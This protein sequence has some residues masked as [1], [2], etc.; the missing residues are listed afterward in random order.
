M[1]PPNWGKR[2]VPPTR[3]PGPAQALERIN[4]TVKTTDN[5]GLVTSSAPVTISVYN[6]DTDLNWLPDSWE[7]QFFGAI[8]QNPN[9]LAPAGDGYTILQ[10]YDLGRSP[11]DFY[12]GVAPSVTMISGNNQ[13]GL[14][15]TYLPQ[16][17]T[18]RV[19]GTSG[20]LQKNAPVTFSIATG[21]G[22][23]GLSS[24]SGAI[25][26]SVT[27]RTGTNGLASVYLSLS[28]T[29]GTPMTRD[30]YWYRVFDAG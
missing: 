23:L 9:A 13:A 27:V 11:L 16:P 3:S 14:I 17:L 7:L 5:Y 22:S 8:G 1:A 25:G 26:S 18:V 21:G 30:C 24:T 15:N 6:D 20:A 2:P 4:L 19:S 12:Q 10:E 28:N 29:T